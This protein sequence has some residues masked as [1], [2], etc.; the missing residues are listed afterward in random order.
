MAH[1]GHVLEMRSLP[2]VPGKFKKTAVK[3]TKVPFKGK[4]YEK[5]G[6]ASLD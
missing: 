5:V 3:V 6:G 1:A 4:G 2:H